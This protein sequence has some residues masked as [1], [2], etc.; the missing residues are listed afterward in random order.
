MKEITVLVC[1]PDG[2][3]TVETRQVEDDW[4]SAPAETEPAGGETA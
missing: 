2:T 1:R 4:F 3:Q